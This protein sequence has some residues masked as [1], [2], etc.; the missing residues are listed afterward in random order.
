MQITEKENDHDHFLV[1]RVARLGLAS[2]SS[3]FSVL[4]LVAAKRLL[5][6]TSSVSLFEAGAALDLKNLFS[7]LLETAG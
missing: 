7:R 6:S 1:E 5:K 4:I 2:C 3:A